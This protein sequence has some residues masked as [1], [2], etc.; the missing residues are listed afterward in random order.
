M[1]RASHAAR[2]RGPAQPER[3][4]FLNADATMPGNVHDTRPAGV[5]V[6][7]DPRRSWRTSLASTIGEESIGRGGLRVALDLSLQ[8]GHS[9]LVATLDD[10]WGSTM[11]TMG[12][13]PTAR[14]ATL[15]ARV[16]NA[17]VTTS[18]MLR[19]FGVSDLHVERPD[20]EPWSYTEITE[21]H[22]TAAVTGFVVKLLFWTEPNGL[23]A[24]CADYSIES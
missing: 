18:L 24:R 22:A 14:V 21:A 2:G 16:T 4:E 7:G 8:S 11:R 1:T 20:G 10:L 15:I 19:L 9:S 13:D 6:T 23:T 5:H 17:G 12:F 3:C